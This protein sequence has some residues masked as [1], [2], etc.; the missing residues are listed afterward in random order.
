MTRALDQ[1]VIEF[2][3]DFEKFTADIQFL[4]DEIKQEVQKTLDEF[5]RNQ[6]T[7]ADLISKLD[8]KI[9][10]EINA[11]RENF[12]GLQK[13]IDDFKNSTLDLIEKQPSA[14][15]TDSE[16]LSEIQEEHGRRLDEIE[17]S[18]DEI[19]Q[20]K[21][22][23]PEKL[24]E[25]LIA[26]I[27]M[28]GERVSKA[29]SEINTRFENFSTTISSDSAE[30]QRQISESDPESFAPIKESNLFDMTNFEVVPRDAVTKLT[31]LFKKQTSAIKNFIEKQE[32]KLAE[33]EE[34]IKTYDEE[35]TRLLE[36]LD[37]RVKRNF[38]ISMG[39]VIAVIV[40]SVV[41]N[42]MI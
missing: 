28:L 16:N 9:Q 18:F 21:E 2:N 24:R 31:A 26:G 17:K 35:N 6:D 38:R 23:T 7:H 10:N 15:P 29:I 41:I 14:K 19:S 39:A 1:E 36:L 42:L 37:K 33:F 11:I 32:L 13:E 12:N 40:I 34:L 25:E 3:E 8:D 4:V 27:R 5:Q 20:F 30:E 22:L